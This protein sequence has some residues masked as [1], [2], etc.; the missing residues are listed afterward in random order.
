MRRDEVKTLRVEP[1][2][3]IDRLQ[4]PDDPRQS[5]LHYASPQLMRAVRWMRIVLV[6]DEALGVAS[7]SIIAAAFV[8]LCVLLMVLGREPIILIAPLIL[9]PFAVWLLNRLLHKL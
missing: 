4:A 8:G 2:L 6:G 5:I 7:R 1:R 3:P 9:V